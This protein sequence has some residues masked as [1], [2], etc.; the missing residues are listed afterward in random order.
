MIDTTCTDPRI[1]T[2]ELLRLTEAVEA[3]ARTL[4]GIADASQYKQP[5][6]IAELTRPDNMI[7]LAAGVARLATAAANAAGELN[8]AVQDGLLI[9]RPD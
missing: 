7:G 8:Q 5:D 1:Q 3:A 4:A 6:Y 9:R 2:A